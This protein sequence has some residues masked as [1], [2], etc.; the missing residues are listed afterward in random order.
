MGKQRQ[1]VKRERKN[2]SDKGR[3]EMEIEGEI[4]RKTENRKTGKK[5][6]AGEE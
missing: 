6:R 3:K 5:E 1:S 4:K 2:L